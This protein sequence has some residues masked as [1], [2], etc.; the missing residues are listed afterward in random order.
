[1][2][3]QLQRALRDFLDLAHARRLGVLPLRE[4]PAASSG[5]VGGPILG[6]LV[7]EDFD[8][9]RD[10]DE[11]ERRLQRIVRPGA[12]A[13]SNAAA[14]RAIPFLHT[15][16]RLTRIRWFFQAG[17]L[18]KTAIALVAVLACAIAMF[19]I[20]VD[21]E[22]PGRGTLQP[23]AIRHLFAP[24]EGVMEQVH[25]EHG[26]EVTPGQ[27]LLRL[28]KP[29]LDLKLTEVVGDLQ[30]AQQ[31]L[32]SVAARRFAA[33]RSGG[34]SVEEKNQLA[35]EQESLKERVANLTRQ[36]QI[37]QRR[38]GTLSI[39]SPIKGQVLTWDVAD[40]LADRPVA[41]GAK[42]LT[43]AD[44]SGPW[45]L[46]LQ[47][48]DRHVRHLLDARRKQAALPVTYRLATRPQT[49]YRGTLEEVAVRSE[50][51]EGR[52]KPSVTVL[53]SVRSADLKSPHP[54]AETVARITCGR[55]P[56]GYV[57]FR[58]LW[59]AIQLHVLF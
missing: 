50:V 46:E 1:M 10:R 19:L 59:E 35:A 7:G 18:P 14:Y 23:R 44:P 12:T 51:A 16:T 57:L 4:S 37:L 26:Q 39:H 25:I 24:E 36:Q 32:Q 8:A 38:V 43:V 22:I 17:R 58:D 33:G 54:G 42:L 5:E 20:P 34:A 29:E 41:R 56:V 15:L 31:L 45:S 11:F 28:K 3:P 9:H 52:D 49:T 30:T 40:R 48:D 2:A 53:V 27:L 21:F 6:L 55:R 47:V 13:L